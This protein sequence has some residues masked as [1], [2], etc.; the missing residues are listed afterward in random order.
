MFIQ[1]C[2]GI[3][4]IIISIVLVIHIGSGSGIVGGGGDDGGGGSGNGNGNGSSLTSLGWVGFWGV[5][6]RRRSLSPTTAITER[7]RRRWQ[8]VDHDAPVRFPIGFVSAETS[9]EASIYVKTKSVVVKRIKLPPGGWPGCG[10]IG[11]AGRWSRDPRRYPTRAEPRKCDRFM[12]YLFL[13]IYIYIYIFYV[14]SLSLYI[15]ISIYIYTYIYILIYI[16]TLHYYTYPFHVS[17]SP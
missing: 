16:Y 15:Y 10:P 17:A 13:Y 8:T 12:L 14:F 7:P 11:A 4:I 2:L 1:G 3:Y 5:E 6:L 9:K